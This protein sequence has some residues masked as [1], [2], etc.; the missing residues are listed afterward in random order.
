MI[1]KKE[2]YIHIYNKINNDLSFGFI[3]L[4][5]VIMLVLNLVENLNRQRANKKR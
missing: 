5:F 1:F 2:R 4:L 3:Y